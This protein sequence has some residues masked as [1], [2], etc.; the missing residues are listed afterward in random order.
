MVY[1]YDAICHHFFMSLNLADIMCY[2]EIFWQF[3]GIGQESIAYS[4]LVLGVYFSYFTTKC[5]LCYLL[6]APWNGTS[7]EYKQNIP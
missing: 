7:N 3:S 2:L 5:M 1:N 4:K 6:E